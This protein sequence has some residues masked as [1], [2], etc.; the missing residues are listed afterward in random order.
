MGLGECGTGLVPAK[1][2]GGESSK[3]VNTKRNG[4]GRRGKERVRS[5][6]DRST[7]ML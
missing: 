4:R 7:G 2:G 3:Q 6:T 1:D 5:P